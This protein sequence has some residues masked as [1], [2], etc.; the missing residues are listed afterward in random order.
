MRILVTGGAGFIGSWVAEEFLKKGHK[1][2]IIDNLS[3]GKEKNIPDG[4]D[5]VKLDILSDRLEELFREKKF[6]AVDHHAAQIDLRTS[7][8]NPEND[9]KANVLATLKLLHLCA[10]YEVKKFIFASSGGAIYSEDLPFPSKEGREH[11]PPTPY[12]I[13]KLTSEKHLNFYSKYYGLNGIV[14][15]YSNIYGPRQRATEE[16]GVVPIFI[17]QMLNKKE[18]RIFG[19]GKQTRDFLYV[20]DVVQAN[21]LALEKGGSGVFNISSG[22]ETTVNQ[23]FD[24][25]AELTDYNRKPVYLP[26]RKGEVKRS[27]LDNRRALDVLGFEPSYT[28]KEGLCRTVESYK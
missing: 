4:A 28:I 26:P 1:V 13:H 27:L 6:D 24:I 10:R 22:K 14:L 21:V 19:D 23:L 18:V 17:R 7:I 5:F 12:G 25:L 2:C 9:L 16:S 11:F 8:D 20:E 15:R 3:T